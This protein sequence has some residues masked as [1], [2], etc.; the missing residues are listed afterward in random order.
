MNY[1]TTYTTDKDGN[2]ITV[3][4]DPVSGQYASYVNGVLQPELI[5]HNYYYELSDDI[6]YMGK[7]EGRYWTENAVRASLNPLQY[8]HRAWKEETNGTIVYIKNRHSDLNSAVVDMEEFFWIKL[9]AKP[10]YG[11]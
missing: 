9:R 6:T 2:E 4:T 7:D 11:K 10:I 3:V 8:A 1:E 5:R